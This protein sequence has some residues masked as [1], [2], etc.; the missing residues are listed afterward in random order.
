MLSIII[1]FHNES[2]LAHQTLRS[3][4]ISAS[5]AA[6]FI[7]NIEFILVLDR[8]T[9]ETRQVI[10]NYPDYSFPHIISECDFGDVA[11]A[12]NHGINLSSGNV[13]AICDG[14][15]YYSRNWLAESYLLSKQSATTIVHPE[16]FVSFGDLHHFTKHMDIH[17]PE[18]TTRGLLAGNYWG[19]WVVTSR[20]TFNSCR[21]QT[22]APRTKTGYWAEDW[23]WNCE[24]I[25]RGFRHIL[26][27]RTAVFYRR[28]QSGVSGWV[29]QQ[30]NRH[31]IAPT[32]L[33]NSLF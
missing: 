12:R 3:L 16:Y 24:T 1:T 31:K 18:Y 26:C 10:T 8:P 13:L 6:S 2:I 20:E 27:P 17:N 30:G 11:P 21:Y 4:H 32:S 22:T 14:D 15:D 19:P 33:F 23:H 29:A 5:F 9:L 7:K 25:A 28:R